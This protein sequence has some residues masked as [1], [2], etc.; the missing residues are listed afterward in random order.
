VLFITKVLVP[1]RALFALAALIGLA[2]FALTATASAS[3]TPTL[4]SSFGAFVR[5]QAI[6]VDQSTGDVYVLDA[7]TANVQRFDADGD[8]TAFTATGSNVL[9]GST[10]PQGAFS[11]DSPSGGA[12]I[13]VD[14]SGGATD[15]D[16]YVVSSGSDAF[17]GVID[18]FGATGAY[19]GQLPSPDAGTA[20]TELCGVAVGPSGTVYAGD[21]YGNVD[22]WTPAASPAT[23]ADY[24]AQITGLAQ[25]T[26][27]VAVTYA[28]AGALTKYQASDF[29]THAPAGTT[30]DFAATALAVDPS[31]DDLYADEGTQ[32]VQY[33]SAASSLA[34]FGSGDIGSSQ[35]VAVN[36]ATTQV[37]VTD[38]S[39][40]TV[41]LYAPPPGA[42][43]ITAVVAGDVRPLRATLQ[44]KVDPGSTATHYR[45][46]YGTDTS[47]GTNVPALDASIGQAG[48][49]QPVRQ[50]A[51]GLQP[52]TTYHFRVVATSTLGTVTG[53]D[54][55]FTTPP[56]A[57]VT[58]TDV[59]AISVMVHGTINAQG[60][61]ATYH[62]EYGADTGYGHS[63]AEADGGSGS[64]DVAVAKPIPGLTPGT[65]YHVRL[66]AQ[67]AG[68]RVSSEDATFTT[69]PAA[70]VTTSAVTDVTP[71]S[72]RLNA[73][74]DT[75]GNP[76]TYRISVQSLTNP[77]SSATTIANL[78]ATDG[79]QAVSGVVS[80]LPPGSS[81]VVR[82]GATVGSFTSYGDQVTFATPG[83][84]PDVP[85]LPPAVVAVPYGCAAPHLNPVNVHPKPGDTVTVTGTDLGVGGAIAAGALQVQPTSWS[86]TLVKFTVPGDAAG[87]LPLTV[88]CGTASNTV[89]LAIYHAPDNA[90]AIAKSS[91]KG[92]VA[93]LSV[94][95]PGPGKVETAA[96]N[97]AAKQITIKKAS[98]AKV[99]VK[100]NAAGR[101]ALAKAKSRTLRVSVRVRFTAAGGTSSTQT[102][103]VTF[104]RAKGK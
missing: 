98:T 69:L 28:G 83:L 97:T 18:I 73:V 11:F 43:V 7:G 39:T 42:P 8:P 65:T 82:A 12:Q 70:A 60:Q 2:A 31:N 100:L 17:H 99:E 15:G 63:T 74:V 54:A 94:K 51:G 96:K 16:I 21:Y 6:T 37:Y 80:D 38:A 64:T 59:E 33:D 61:P 86:P 66:V 27:A 24:D 13:A 19:R 75:H 87:T 62:F 10:T 56:A 44:A 71:T 52:E 4:Q 53:D 91:V 29:G 48:S 103:S 32:I 58:A 26:C 79:P 9:D 104:T 36:A 5:P 67:V 23:S 55:T 95:V 102:K 47:Y 25:N 22:R 35:G 93:T 45:F 90:F 3:G 49:G 20:L 92:S 78:S 1:L 30:I 46:E 68:Q 81:F 14:N 72:A 50:E 77:Y 57:S 40:G 89:G 85:V 84:P 41:H 101:K 88:D 76:G 34:T